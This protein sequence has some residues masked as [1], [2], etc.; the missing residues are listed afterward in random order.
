MKEIGIAVTILRVEMNE[1]RGREREIKRRGGK[2]HWFHGMEEE[3]E[4]TVGKG[5]VFS[6]RSRKK[7]G[8]QKEE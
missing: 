3:D 6:S 5:L 4:A 2:C 7:K 8:E 1:G